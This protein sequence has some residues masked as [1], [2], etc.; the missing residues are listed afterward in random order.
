MDPLFGDKEEEEVRGN[1]NK[2][3]RPISFGCP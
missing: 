2:E 3:G 1:I